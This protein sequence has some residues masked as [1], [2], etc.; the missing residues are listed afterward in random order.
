MNTD[1]KIENLKL[2]HKFT[3]E[4]GYKYICKCCG[5]GNKYSICSNEY[6]FDYKYNL[7][8]RDQ[9]N[10]S[11]VKFKLADEDFHYLFENYGNFDDIVDNTFHQKRILYLKAKKDL[12]E[13]IKTQ[14]NIEQEEFKKQH[15]H[16]SD[17]CDDI[18]LV[19]KQGH[20]QGQEQEQDCSNTRIKY[21]T[22]MTPY[23]IDESSGFVKPILISDELAIFLNEPLG[24]KIPRI[25][26]TKRINKYIIENNLK[27]VDNGRIIIP[28]DNL[29]NLLKFE[30]TAL[31]PNLT[32][33]NIQKYLS[34]HLIR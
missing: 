34:R 31:Q 29:K 17:K 11:Y 22:R 6:C 4:N 1:N 14:S 23:K 30:S 7:F 3:P 28:D 20:E 15:Y 26:V 5:N 8:L 25:E 16:L 12:E 32:F 24:S 19:Q 33:F 18:P 10:V 21:T 27:N 13:Y 9:A 2:S